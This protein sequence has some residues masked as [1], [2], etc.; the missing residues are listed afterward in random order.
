MPESAPGRAP[1]LPRKPRSQYHHGDLRRALLQE[2]VRTIAGEGPGGLTLR[3]VGKRLGVSRSA[4]YRH[5]S[6]KSALLAAVAGDGFVRLRDDL[7]RA[8]QE[9]GGGRRGLERMGIAYVRFAVANPSHYRVMFGDFRNL[10]AKDPDLQA[11]AA[12]AFDVLLQ[13]VIA[14]RRTALVRP[15]DPRLLS[16]FIWATVH[17]VAML[18]IDGQLGPEPARTERLD[19]LLPLV[20]KRVR[21][22]IDAGRSSPRAPRSPTR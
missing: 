18:A 19:R 5:F 3:D 8:W 2:A 1:A 15:D 20:L 17:G 13:A 10:C 7:E 21:S 14:L 9:A 11:A 6:D 22:G 4:L 16:E 12:A